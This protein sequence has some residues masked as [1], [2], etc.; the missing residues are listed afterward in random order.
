MEA[1]DD[2][3]LK[4]EFIEKVPDCK[5]KTKNGD[6]LS[7]HYTGVLAA[8][9]EKFSSSRDL[10]LAYNFT[11]GR[12]EVIRGYDVGLLGMCVGEKRRLTVPPHM[13]E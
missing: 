1:E 6:F 12:G 13:G 5:S 3:E 2:K 8:S 4:I 11:L 7:V 9:G 10:G